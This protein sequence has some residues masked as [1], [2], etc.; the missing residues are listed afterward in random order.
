MLLYKFLLPNCH[1]TIQRFFDA[2][3]SIVDSK[4]VGVSES[5]EAVG[6]L[7]VDNSYKGK[8]QNVSVSFENC[9]GDTAYAVAKVQYNEILRELSFENSKIESIAKIIYEDGTS[10]AVAI[11]LIFDSLDGDNVA[12][13]RAELDVPQDAVKAELILGESITPPETNPLYNVNK[14]L[15]LDTEL[16]KTNKAKVEKISAE[17]TE[18]VSESTGEIDNLSDVTIIVTYPERVQAENN[19]GISIK[20]K[21]DGFEGV[22]EAEFILSQVYNNDTLM[23]KLKQDIN[24]EH[25]N[26]VTITLDNAK[27][28]TAEGS[29]LYHGK[30]GL[31]VNR[32]LH[33][34]S[35]TFVMSSGE[36]PDNPDVPEVPT[37]PDVPETPTTPDVPEAPTTPDVPEVP[38]TPDVPEVTTTPDVPETPTIQDDSDTTTEENITDTE[39]THPDIPN[40]GIEKLMNENMNIV[41]SV[42]LFMIVSLVIVLM[43]T[44]KKHNKKHF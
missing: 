3:S 24:Q 22:N 11:P 30:T 10:T 26:I 23:F 8:V 12:V 15:S 13:Y 40:T 36:T 34:V 18:I 29:E 43:L 5:M 27:I 44:R 20:A 28:M 32:D 2:F 16:P 42:A 38:T 4:G 35:Q 1:L 21:I 31:S 14:T 25:S 41:Y 39:T 33:N 37:K 6:T 7:V 17:A 19:E 9:Y